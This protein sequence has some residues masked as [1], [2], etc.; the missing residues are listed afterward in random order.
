MGVLTVNI[1]G[2]MTCWVLRIEGQARERNEE[3]AEKSAVFAMM[4]PT[5]SIILRKRSE[6]RETQ[7]NDPL[8][9]SSF[10]VSTR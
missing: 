9:Q 4:S 1:L 6:G 8:G 7:P 10:S 5:A 2:F 3:E